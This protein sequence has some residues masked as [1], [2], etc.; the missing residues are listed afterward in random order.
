VA[1]RGV[2]EIALD[3]EDRLRRIELQHG[4]DRAAERQ[5]R[6]GAHIVAGLGVPAVPAQRG[7]ALA[8]RGEL[9]G[10]GRRGGGAAEEAEPLAAALGEFVRA[11][12]QRLGEGAGGGDA[13]LP[14]DRRRAV[15]VVEVENAG[16]REDAG[17]AEARRVLRIALDLDRPSHLVDEQDPRRVAVA[18]EGGGEGA[19]QAGDDAR[20]RLDIGHRLVRR[21]RRSAAGDAAERQRGAHELQDPAAVEPR[22]VELREGGK[23]VAQEPHQVGLARQLGEAAPEAAPRLAA[24]APP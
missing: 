9:R 8:E 3:G 5:R 15:R 1:G 4:V 21:R 11:Q 24:E 23:L 18:G 13:A 7:K 22:V 16:L 10:E 19:R 20:R 6:A 12:R 2:E 14:Q 17:R